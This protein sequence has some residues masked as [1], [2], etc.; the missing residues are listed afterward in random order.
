MNKALWTIAAALWVCAGAA[1]AQ[2]VNLGRNL[3]ATCAGCHA[4]RGLAAH[5]DFGACDRCH[6][7][8]DDGFRGSTFDHAT[9][10]FTLN[11]RHAT[12]G[13]RDCHPTKVQGYPG[14]T[15]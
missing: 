9:T 14:T 4:E 12:L 2:D 7:T 13:C 1:H 5:G 8:A 15:P 11:G 3:A 10:G 6:S